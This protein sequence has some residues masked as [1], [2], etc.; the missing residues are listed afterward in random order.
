MVES[1][2]DM[3]KILKCNH[4]V[5]EVDH[6]GEVGSGDLLLRITS[7]YPFVV[8]VDV[9]DNIDYSNEYPILNSNGSVSLLYSYLGIDGKVGISSSYNQANQERLFDISKGHG[10]L[11]NSNT[12]RT[13]IEENS[14]LGSYLLNGE[15]I[16][17][18]HK[19]DKVPFYEKRN[20]FAGKFKLK[21]PNN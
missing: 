2:S 5:K 14:E 6:I 20:T 16:H 9:V 21:I 10:Y 17:L 8:K 13:H 4:T 12:L 11:V 15:M 19:E 1:L 3:I 7:T 18:N